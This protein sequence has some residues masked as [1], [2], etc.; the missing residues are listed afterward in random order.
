MADFYDCE[1][2]PEWLRNGTVHDAAEDYLFC[3][4]TSV[5]PTELLVMAY[6]EIADGLCEHDNCY[7]RSEDEDEVVNTVAFIREHLADWLEEDDVKE[8]MASHGN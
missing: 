3:T 8:W 4:D 6:S 2:N 7:E 1:E 5:W